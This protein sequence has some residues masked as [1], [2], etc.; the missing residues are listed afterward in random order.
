[1]RLQIL[2]IIKLHQAIE[3]IRSRTDLNKKFSYALI[4]TKAQIQSIF[5]AVAEMEK[6]PPEIQEF[7]KERIEAAR[8][9]AK[10]KDNGDIDADGVVIR[11][12]NPQAYNEAVESLRIKYNGAI[13]AHE[14]SQQEVAEY[15]KREDKV[16]V[17]KV[18]FDLFPDTI[19]PE[20]LEALEPMIEERKDD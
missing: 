3:A 2:K 16:E 1:M 8:R 4:K 14:K 18:P 7:E 12:D 9:F 15:L 11:L 6:L 19:S 20:I 5:D 17:H 10:R 13:V